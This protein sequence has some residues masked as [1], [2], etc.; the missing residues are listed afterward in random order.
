MRSFWISNCFQIQLLLNHHAPE[1]GSSSP[2]AQTL[3]SSSL[4]V[5]NP[6]SRLADSHP[7]LWCG[8]KTG[9]LDVPTLC[10]TMFS[11]AASMA[12]QSG[13]GVRCCI[14]WSAG[15]IGIRAKVLVSMQPT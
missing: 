12:C 8:R 11:S 2:S 1:K 15:F 10:S 13:D 4:S 14:A 6:Q 3:L 5:V 9:K 7:W